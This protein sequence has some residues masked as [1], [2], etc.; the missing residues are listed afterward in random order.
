[1][2]ILGGARDPDFYEFLGKLSDP[3]VKSSFANIFNSLGYQF[4]SEPKVKPEIS[5][6][7]TLRPKVVDADS[8]YI[9][10][11]IKRPF[12]MDKALRI[13]KAMLDYLANESSKDKK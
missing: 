1:M 8:N 3:I 2:L 12:V 11:S 9:E 6:L 10:I 13:Q 4:I 7:K 5:E